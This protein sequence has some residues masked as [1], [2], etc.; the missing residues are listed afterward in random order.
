MPDYGI[1]SA[2]HGGETLRWTTS[3]VVANA[4]DDV[5]LGDV[6]REEVDPCAPGAVRATVGR[7]VE[8]VRAAIA[9][10]AN[11]T[12]V[13][14]AY[15]TQDGPR[16][17][18]VERVLGAGHMGSFVEGALSEALHDPALIAFHPRGY[19]PQAFGCDVRV[20]RRDA[21][22]EDRVRERRNIRLRDLYLKASDDEGGEAMAELRAYVDVLAEA[23]ARRYRESGWDASTRFF[24][25]GS[26]VP[27]L[28]DDVQYN[29]VRWFDFRRRFAERLIVL[30]GIDHCVC[31]K[32]PLDPPSPPTADITATY[33]VDRMVDAP[34]LAMVA[35]GS[36]YGE[37]RARCV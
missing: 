14:V 11:G 33:L 17:P 37:E 29:L 30:L 27:E 36:A 2:L 7:Y 18:E 28:K 13:P 25:L 3:L 4:A 9:L 24:L 22:V 31:V 34:T 1:A 35:G 21:T 19:R 12:R 16:I 6:W 20:K 10:Q 5:V 23:Y 32:A 26:H 8:S 15:C